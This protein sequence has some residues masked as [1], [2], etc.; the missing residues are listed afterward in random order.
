[1]GVIARSAKSALAVSLRQQEVTSALEWG[2]HI[3]SAGCGRNLLRQLLV[4]AEEDVGVCHPDKVRL[5]ITLLDDFKKLRASDL[6]RPEYSNK[7]AHLVKE[8]ASAPKSRLTPNVSRLCYEFVNPTLLKDV[9]KD[10]DVRITDVAMEWWKVR[11]A[12]FVEGQIVRGEKLKPFT[13]DDHLEGTELEW[14]M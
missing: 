11:T 8:I 7:I 13:D 14:V 4:S 3:L 5:C 1:M 10:K 2:V 9:R 12:E 6:I